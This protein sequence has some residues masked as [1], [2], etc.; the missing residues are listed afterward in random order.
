V[1]GTLQGTIQLEYP[2][3]GLRCH[4][5]FPLRSP[6]RDETLPEDTAAAQIEAAPVS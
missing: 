6:S 3:G 1:K 5:T 4:L 2:A